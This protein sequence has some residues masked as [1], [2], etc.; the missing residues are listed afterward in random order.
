MTE[1]EDGS[2]GQ[3]GLRPTGGTIEIPAM[4]FEDEELNTGH[5]MLALYLAS[6]PESHDGLVVVNVSATASAWISEAFA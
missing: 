1:R 2:N 6:L 5:K 3:S 4:L